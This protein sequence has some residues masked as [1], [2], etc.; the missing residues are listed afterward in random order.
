[1][2]YGTYI[3]TSLRKFNLSDDEVEMIMIDNGITK[4]DAVDSVVA[5]SAIYKSFSSW[6]PVRS[7]ISEGGVSETWNFELVKLYYNSICIELGLENVIS[8]KEDSVRDR[9]NLW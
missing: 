2:D 6:L 4:T 1:M 5:K 9:S 3:K 8:G 7:S